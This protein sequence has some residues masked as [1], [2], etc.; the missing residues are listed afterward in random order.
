MLLYS[1]ILREEDE[2]LMFYHKEERSALLNSTGALEAR[3][4]YPQMGIVLNYS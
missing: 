2:W 4:S 3:D 1:G